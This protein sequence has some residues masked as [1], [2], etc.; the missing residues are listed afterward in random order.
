MAAD[1]KLKDGEV[2]RT[3]RVA[4]ASATVIEA[5]DL[6]EIA[7]GLMVKA[8]ATGAK[9][10]FTPTGSAN[11]ETVMEVTIG[12]NFTLIGTADAAFAVTDKGV[13]RD[14]VVNGGAQQIDIGTTSTAVLTVGIGTDA[15]TASSAAN[16]EVR[17][18]KPI[19]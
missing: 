9:L 4:V 5:G 15:G 13:A 18:A 8:T 14:L 11:G 12:N 1:F 6:V 3:T 7:S 19:F 17:I 2:V 16:V 10:A